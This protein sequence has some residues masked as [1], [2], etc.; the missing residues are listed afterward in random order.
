MIIGHQKQWELLTQ[1]LESQKIPHAY[2]FSGQ[3]ELG[4]KTIAFEFVKLIFCQ[5][6]KRKPCQVCRSCKDLQKGIH[7]DFFAIQSDKKEITI[8]QIRS[9]IWKVSLYPSIAPL[10]AA[11]IDNAHQMNPEAQ[12][13]LLKTLEEPK[14]E[15]LFILIT[16]H[17]QLLFSTISSRAQNM[18]FFPVPQTEINKYL[19]EKG[20]SAKDTQEIATLA[21]GR[22]GAALHLSRNPQ[23]I[24]EQNKKI[25][26]IVQLENADLPT[27]FQY[28]KDLISKK[29]NLREVLSIWLW[30]FRSTL[31]QRIKESPDS[32]SKLKNTIQALQRTDF[33][34]STTNVNQKL[35][36]E[37]FFME[38]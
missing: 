24:K 2:V 4:K 15:A 31:L 36:L 16:S 7:P 20:C 38:F 9:L 30:Y 26:E 10:K 34:I 35:A 13:C 25:K 12:N 8:S 27:R 33:L 19:Q 29:E 21:F 28:V 18:K 23:V 14:G 22:P 32:V 11:I 5:D 37:V 6:L 1:S 3:S 17:P